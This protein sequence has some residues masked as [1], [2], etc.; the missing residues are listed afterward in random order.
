MALLIFLVCAF[1]FVLG[2]IFVLGSSIVGLARTHVPFVP[3]TVTDIVQ[4]A[5]RLRLGPADV[6]VDLGSG[7]GRVIF[8]IEKL[9]RAKVR[10]YEL[11]LWTHLL[12]KL[13]KMLRSSKA[14]LV[15]G[16][17]FKGN[18][19][20]AT[21]VYCYLY[22]PLMKSVGEKIL[23]NCKPGTRVVS[24]DFSIPNLERIDYWKSGG[25]HEIFVYK[26]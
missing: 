10:G 26:V 23:E 14:E 15:L 21:V 3:T 16:N 22:P 25:K 13:K 1:I 6:F 9:T 12:A 2:I 11:T 17:F 20:D 18:L 19:K 4:I 24:R 8:Q 5:E 7:D